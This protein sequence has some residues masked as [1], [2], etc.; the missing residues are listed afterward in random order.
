MRTFKGTPGTFYAV[1]PTGQTMQGY[2]QPWGVV[3]HVPGSTG[4]SL[5]CGCFGD[6]DGGIEH[7]EANAKL[8]AASK[9]LL[10]ALQHCVHWFDQLKP[11]DVA[12]YKIAIAKATT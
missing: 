5:V 9:E 6:T 12:R 4:P 3:T 10:E 7:A 1:G 2:H 11:E 8:F